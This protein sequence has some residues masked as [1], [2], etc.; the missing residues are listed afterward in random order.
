MLLT[1]TLVKGFLG[2]STGK[3]LQVCR[4]NVLKTGEVCRHL[5]PR[6]E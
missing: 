5:T 1:V 3:G 4:E 6:E 2:P